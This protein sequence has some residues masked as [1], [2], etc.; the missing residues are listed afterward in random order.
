MRSFCVPAAVLL[1]VACSAV[2]T[3]DQPKLLNIDTSCLA[4]AALAPGSQGVKLSPSY[5]GVTAS[6][7]TRVASPLGWSLNADAAAVDEVA[8][9]Y[10]GPVDLLT[11]SVC[12]TDQQL[13]L[14][15]VAP[16]PVGV[17]FNNDQTAGVAD[18]PQ[19]RNW[20][21]NSQ[22]C[23]SA[24]D[25]SGVIRLFYAADA[26]VEYHRI[27]ETSFYAGVNG[28]G[29][30]LSVE[31]LT[32][33]EHAVQ[34]YVLHDQAGDEIVFFGH[35]GVPDGASGQLWKY[36]VAK[37]TRT[38]VTEA[39]AYVGDVSLPYTAAHDGYENGLIVTAFDSAGRK[40]VYAYASV[41]SVDR[42][43]S[44]VAFS[45]TSSP[46]TIAQVDYAYYGQTAITTGTNNGTAG[47]LAMIR[48]T[49][50]TSF[51][52]SGS[53][54]AIDDVRENRFYYDGSS[55]L[56]LVLGYEGTRRH[57]VSTGGSPVSWNANA[58]TLATALNNLAEL[59]VVYQ[60]SS[61][62]R[63][64][65]VWF[66]GMDG[67]N[68]SGSS[69]DG[70]HDIA[71]EHTAYSGT[72]WTDRTVVKLP[73]FKRFSGSALSSPSETTASS[74]S[75][76]YFDDI[77]QPLSSVVSDIDPATT[78]STPRFW[79]TGVERDAS[80]RLIALNSAANCTGYSNHN[81]TSASRGTFTREASVGAVTYFERY[82]TTGTTA[83]FEG[84]VKGVRR[85]VG[86]GTAYG[87]TNY[88]SS[89]TLAM[90]EPTPSWG[91]S[92]IKL[93]KPYVTAARVYPTATTTE[94]A[95]GTFNETTYTYGWWGATVVPQWIETTLPAVSAARNGTGV[96]DTRKT[97]F[98]HVGQ[99]IATRLP[100][101]RLDLSE[102]D[103]AT[104][105]LVRQTTD[106]AKPTSSFVHYADL[107]SSDSPDAAVIGQETTPYEVVTEYSYD[108]L[109]RSSQTIA[110]PAKTI[111][112][113]R[114]VS[115]SYYT[116]LSDRRLV[117]LDVPAV[118]NTSSAVYCG[119]VSASVVN[120]A[121]LVEEAGQICLSDPTAHSTTN[122][123][124]FTTTATPRTWLAAPGSL[125]DDC[126]AKA[127]HGNTAG[128]SQALVS[129]AV[130]LTSP[131]GSRIVQSRRYTNIPTSGSTVADFL[132]A[133]DT[134]YDYTLAH[135]NGL[136][137]IDRTEDFTRTIDVNSFDVLGRVVQR[138]RG[139][140]E[141]GAGAN[142]RTHT[143]VAYDAVN[144]GAFTTGNLNVAG[145]NGNV[146]QV[147]QHPSGAFNGS[148][149]LHSYVRYDGLDNTVNVWR[150]KG[151]FLASAVD[152]LGR[153]VSAAA[154]D[155]ED[156]GWNSSGPAPT[157][158]IFDSRYRQRFGEVAYDERGRIYRRTVA[159]IDASGNVSGT[160][161]DTMTSDTFWGANDV[162]K[163]RTGPTSQLF[164]RDRLCQPKT[165]MTAVFT[166]SGGQSQADAN[167]EMIAANPANAIVVQQTNFYRDPTQHFVTATV[168]A[169]RGTADVG[170]TS[171]GAISIGSALPTFGPLMDIPGY[172]VPSTNPP[173]LNIHQNT[174]MDNLEFQLR[175]GRMPSN[176][177]LNMA[178]KQYD[179][180]LLMPRVQYN[181]GDVMRHSTPPEKVCCSLTGCGSDIFPGY[182]SILDPLPYIEQKQEYD[183][184]F[185]MNKM[186][187]TDTE[188]GEV[189]TIAQKFNPAGQ[190]IHTMKAHGLTTPIPAYPAG[191]DPLSP[192]SGP[193]CCGETER[194]DNEWDK[195]R[196]K[197]E[198]MFLC[199]PPVFSG[200]FNPNDES[201]WSG[202]SN[203]C[204][205]TTSYGY[206][207]MPPDYPPGG[208]SGFYPWNTSDAPT[209]T[210]NDNNLV[211]WNVRPVGE[212]PDIGWHR[213]KSDGSDDADWYT[214]DFMGRPTRSYLF[215]YRKTN[216]GDG[217][218]VPSG[219]PPARIKLYGDNGLVREVRTPSGDH[220]QPWDHLYID[221]DSMGRPTQLRHHIGGYV[222]LGTPT[223]N[224]VLDFGYDRFGKLASHAQTFDGMFPSGCGA[225][226]PVMCGLDRVG[227]PQE[228]VS[229]GGRDLVPWQGPRVVRQMAPGMDLGMAY[230]PVPTETT[231]SLMYPSGTGGYVPLLV[232]PRLDWA[233]GRPTGLYQGDGT[234]HYQTPLTQYGYT[235]MSTPLYRSMLLAGPHGMDAW[236][237]ALSMYVPVGQPSTSPLAPLST[238]GGGIDW[239][240]RE[241]HDVWRPGIDTPPAFNPLL[242]PLLLE[243]EGP[244]N[245]EW[246]GTHL[247]SMLDPASSPAFGGTG[248]S[249]IGDFKINGHDEYTRF[250]CNGRP[251]YWLSGQFNGKG[252]SPSVTGPFKDASDAWKNGLT[253]PTG[254]NSSEA[255]KPGTSGSPP[256]S[257]ITEVEFRWPGSPSGCGSSGAQSGWLM[258]PSGRVNVSHPLSPNYGTG[259][260]GAPAFDEWG[261]HDVLA[262]SEG[263]SAEG[264][265]S[266]TAM[267]GRKM[268][269]GSSVTDFVPAG[270]GTTH[271]PRWFTH[272]AAGNV[273]F[274][275]RHFY[276]YDGSNRLKDVYDVAWSGSSPSMGL[277]QA[278]FDYDG[279]G[280]LIRSIYDTDHDGS[281]SDED[282]EWTPRDHLGRPIGIWR[283]LPGGTGCAKPYQLFGYHNTSFRGE[284]SDDSRGILDAPAVRWRDTD[285]NGTLDETTSY[286]Q[287]FRGDVRAVVSPSAGILEHTRYGLTGRPESFPAA[288]VNF[289][290]QI[291]SADKDSFAQAMKEFANDPDRYDPRADLDRDGDVDDDD[292][293][294][295]NDSVS[296]Y[297]G[298]GGQWQVSSGAGLSPG[299]SGADAGLD[300]R[301]GWRGYWYDSHLQM[302]HVRNRDYDPRQG[303]WLQTDPLG[304]SAGDQNLYRYADGNYSSGYDPEGLYDEF[305]IVTDAAGGMP[306]VI[307]TNTNQ[308]DVR[309]TLQGNGLAAV[310][311]AA[312]AVAAVT[313]E[314]WAPV[315]ALDTLGAGLVSGTAAG[316]TQYAGERAIGLDPDPRIIRNGGITGMVIAPVSNLIGTALTRS[317]SVDEQRVLAEAVRR[318]SQEEAAAPAATVPKPTECEPAPSGLDTTVR[319]HKETVG[320]G[321]KDSHHIIQHKAVDG[322][323]GV[324]R[325][326]AM[327]V[328][329]EGP[330]VDPQTPHGATRIV[331]RQSGGGTLRAEYRIGYKALRYAGYTESEARIIIGKARE[332]F[333]SLGHG[334]DTPTRIPG[335]RPNA[336]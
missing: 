135:Y 186:V 31:S 254:V 41:G 137:L 227:T 203:G 45:G 38:G 166:T 270:G 98:S 144:Y 238:P 241:R 296:K 190:L 138:S 110:N 18:G 288:D 129:Y 128:N 246:S 189:T 188:S 173:V 62:Y 81:A 228:K 326:D 113:G 182:S 287:D 132:G 151:P 72:P 233:L 333:E 13:A 317:L 133:V 218:A 74:W 153:T 44:V 141:S 255:I 95:S 299:H 247:I 2:A 289:D 304:F 293:A 68:T 5:R 101:K 209:H 143:S 92:T 314:V 225:S 336:R 232:E 327:A 277:H 15:A 111:G 223:F 97:W 290:G 8:S 152:N 58:T 57:L 20:F 259:G 159:A 82:D 59:R 256:K 77:G 176:L 185:I 154:F 142:M 119:P 328:N 237:G 6:G 300:N 120:H 93:R 27:D 17:S 275:G 50:P 213:G 334:P 26:F 63:V 274:D 3:A 217:N 172:T 22:P 210:P 243:A 196:I 165:Q 10:L 49:L 34:V 245:I 226:G 60:T 21:Q 130:S 55:R 229:I 160:A 175:S 7:A 100:N 124:R 179:E 136:S 305:E 30:V 236:P 86:K 239:R 220:L 115:Q 198:R 195:G 321:L 24:P 283:Q 52:A 262:A 207:D 253:S 197:L 315:G 286:L 122:P 42:L 125:A 330:A 240:H 187:T 99:A 64:A 216:F 80:R 140:V 65:S 71:Y 4:V 29:G 297:E 266:R 285:S 281:L 205:K 14:P 250:D 69:P 121:G 134:N 51:G 320:A 184:R 248:D 76:Q 75:T 158:S 23:V 308:V 279:P 161:G 222:P 117:R 109:G 199:D 12:Y 258:A 260:G 61:P 96:S 280:Q 149:D 273:K 200:T 105:L 145:R 295:F 212:S 79:I 302:Y 170:V 265:N 294:L 37:G 16:W 164:A 48:V 204:P 329:L 123:S 127:Q 168:T 171:G 148:D 178:L 85:G 331:Q 261:Q 215:P 181:L 252:K 66:D 242:M 87:S 271:Y 155:G 219:D 335:D 40:F 56:K 298:F 284:G 108:A 323:K 307:N 39:T 264:I 126:L 90:Q 221:R 231:D 311:V 316:A 67:S 191:H 183:P 267:E 116:R 103:S 309:T 325:N 313:W 174:A 312:L 54:P 78:S 201:N 318:A 224:D 193:G 202:C 303:Q 244:K 91:T 206:L 268:T 163:A 257:P 70:Q 332:Y 276:Q 319:T 278:H 269:S 84:F 147:F 292:L 25:T 230:F 324:T 32:E 194:T 167:A 114:R 94:G 157:A 306:F 35:S 263:C 235:G 322:L 150:D 234:D 28:A 118:D 282:T 139:T 208:P 83:A 43:V 1:S 106:A 310:T 291:D 9:R 272:D 301:F 19:G 47:D 156:S 112:T 162:V 131:D 46:T 53:D 104:G 169:Q 73:A 33:G 214:Y 249:P 36:T 102:Y 211:L 192:E 11:G 88:I 89:S 177:M 146:T 180:L 251:I 107:P